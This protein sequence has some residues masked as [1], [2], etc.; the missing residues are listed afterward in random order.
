[1]LIPRSVIGNPHPYKPIRT[2]PPTAQHYLPGPGDLVTSW[3]TMRSIENLL[4]E[5]FQIDNDPDSGLP[6][7]ELSYMT[8]ILQLLV[9][10]SLRFQSRG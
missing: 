5:T 6:T 8:T 3:N 10:F 7:E 4:S 9:M 2:M 1:M